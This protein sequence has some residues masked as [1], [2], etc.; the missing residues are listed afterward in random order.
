MGGGA[1]TQTF[2]WEKVDFDEN[3]PAFLSK[4]GWGSVTDN[5]MSRYL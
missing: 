1:Q 4:D 3:A 5:V 2:P